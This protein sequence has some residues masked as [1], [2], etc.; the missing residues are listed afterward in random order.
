MRAAVMHGPGHLSIEEVPDPVLPEGGV[1]VDLVACAVCGTDVKMLQNGHRDL[2]YPRILGHEMVGRVSISDSSE[3]EEGELVQIWPGIAC[4]RCRPCLK[5]IDN[6]CAAQGIFGFNRDGGF[7]QRIA[8]PEE[9]V[10]SKGIVKLPEDADPVTV[11]LAEPLACC[12]NGQELARVGPGDDVL[13]FGGGPIG[14]LHAILAKANGAASVLMT[15]HLRNR[16][17]LIPKGLVD[18]MVDPSEEDIQEVVSKETGG[19]GVDVVPMSTPEVRVDNWILKIMAP[20]GRIS[21]FS[22]PKKDNYEVPFDIRGLHYREICLVG[23]YGNSSRQDRLAVEMMLEGRVDVGWLVTDR[24]PL[25]GLQQAFERASSR[26]GMK[27]VVTK[28]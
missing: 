11:S 15:E 10:R 25:E 20:Q 26:V 5:G 3:V 2:V 18:R 13:I 22:G 14:C 4:G 24:V 23:A 21:V 1:I 19:N 9:S 16:R 6:Q 7:A 8:V 28:F 27:T 12:I 17:E